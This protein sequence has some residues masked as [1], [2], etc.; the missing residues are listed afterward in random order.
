[1]K[2]TAAKKSYSISACSINHSAAAGDTSQWLY[3]FS[4]E[5]ASEI[6]SE[7]SSDTILHISSTWN[8]QRTTIQRIM[9]N[10]LLY[11]SSEK[12]TH[13]EFV[14]IFSGFIRAL[15]TSRV[16]RKVPWAP[17]MHYFI[18]WYKVAFSNA[19]CR[20]R[21][22][23]LIS[24]PRNQFGLIWSKLNP[25]VGLYLEGLGTNLKLSTQ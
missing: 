10:P 11:T 15:Q 8:C 17:R 23:G 5:I 1:M 22:R 12:T 20:R 2:Q 3:K 13:L 4:S 19:H 21:S 9:Q 25:W 14:Y 24:F 18:G 7:F 6:A 16:K